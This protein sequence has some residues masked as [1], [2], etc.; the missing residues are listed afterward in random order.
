MLT[1]ALDVD[2]QTIAMSDDGVIHY[3]HNNT[4]NQQEHNKQ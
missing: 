4:Q 2:C 3:Y 1:K